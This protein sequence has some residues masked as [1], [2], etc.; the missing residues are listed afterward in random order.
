MKTKRLTE[1]SQLDPAS[2]H[3]SRGYV[4][5]RTVFPMHQGLA[6]DTTEALGSADSK[7]I[8]EIRFRQCPLLLETNEKT[9]ML[10][11]F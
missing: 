7:Y 2:S 3:F 11:I 10:H 9:Y 4:L 6:D 1:K 8:P 5:H